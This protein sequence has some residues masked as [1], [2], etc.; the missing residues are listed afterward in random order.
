MRPKAARPY[1]GSSASRL[2]ANVGA[3]LNSVGLT[4]AGK[5]IG[6]WGPVGDPPAQKCQPNGVKPDRISATGGVCV[7]SGVNSVYTSGRWQ[8]DLHRRELRADGLLVPIGMRAFEIIEVLVKSAGALVAKDDLMRAVWPAAIVEE[9]TVWVHIWAI[10]RAFGPDRLMLR[11][12][13][14]RGYRLVG[15]WAGLPHD[16]SPSDTKVGGVDRRAPQ[17]L[18]NIPETPHDLIGRTAA[19]Q[20]LLDLSS[21]YRT[22]TLTGPGGIGK[23]V[24]ALEVARRLLPQFSGNG[25]FIDLS[26]LSDASL[27]ASAVAATIGLRLGGDAITPQTIGRAIGQTKLLLVLDNCEH[28]IEAASSLAEVIVRFCPHVSVPSTSRETL[29]IGGEYLYRVPSLTTPSGGSLKPD[30]I[31]GYSAVQLFIARTKV[32]CS[33]FSPDE[34]AL[35]RIASICEGLDGMPLAIEFAS[36]CAAAIGLQEIENRLSDRFGLLTG[37]RRTA[38]PR[39]QTL[40]ATLEWSYYLLAE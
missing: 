16:A 9:A 8:V 38:P 39:H 28:V 30:A 14:R 11:T 23:T 36:A 29:Q 32:L 37:G 10:R 12:V 5:A 13:S 33:D 31:L 1:N 22:I 4:S 7:S 19:I 25:W 34:A 6:G 17:P 40:A 26:S 24:L 21:A 15:N 20:R 3:N 18:T 27:L 2:L 35:S